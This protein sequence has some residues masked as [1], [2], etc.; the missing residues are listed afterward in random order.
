MDQERQAHP[1]RRVRIR[2]K[3]GR[4]K[5]H[6][7]QRTHNCMAQTLKISQRDMVVSLQSELSDFQLCVA[8]HHVLMRGFIAMVYGL[9]HLPICLALRENQ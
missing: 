5:V 4:T 2:N 9:K 6:G 7:W 8:L 3:E 1:G